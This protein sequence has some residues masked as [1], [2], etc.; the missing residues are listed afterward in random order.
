[1]QAM[2]APPLELT[3]WQRIAKWWHEEMSKCDHPNMYHARVVSHEG[4]LVK[5]CPDCQTGFKVR[6]V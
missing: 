1:M 6:V 5:V 3:L 2:T 4:S